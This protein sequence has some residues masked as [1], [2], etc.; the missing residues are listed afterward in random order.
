MDA[1]DVMSLLEMLL[2]IVVLLIA[3]MFLI[4]Y[5]LGK[6][7]DAVKILNEEIEEINR[8][9]KS[10]LKLMKQVNDAFGK[11]NPNSAALSKLIRLY[12]GVD[13]RERE[14]AWERKYTVILKRFMD[15]AEENVSAVEHSAFRM[16][17][18][19]VKMNEQEFAAARFSCESSKMVL[20]KYATAPYAQLIAV[21]DMVVGLIKQHDEALQVQE[22]AQR[23]GD[24]AAAEFAHKS[25]RERRRNKIVI[26][27][28][29]DE[30][31]VSILDES[32]YQQVQQEP[33]QQEAPQ[34]QQQ[35]QQ[36]QQPIPQQQ[37]QQQQYAQPMPQQSATVNV[38]S[39]NAVQ[40]NNNTDNFGTVNAASSRSNRSRSRSR[41]A[42]KSQQQ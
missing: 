16:A 42:K 22:T 14:E 37:V 27:N 12:D 9:R 23:E 5:V 26:A 35:Y 11:N 33:I 8:C 10:R 2:L 13:T 17:D 41:S 1:N 36:Q 39:S 20:R 30:Y 40:V 19:S 32:S 38:N 18:S 6:R 34:Q 31:G 7:D 29:V 25:E 28:L 21:G 24:E 4:M 3:G 15:Y